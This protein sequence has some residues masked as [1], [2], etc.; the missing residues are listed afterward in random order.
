[1]KTSAI[2][3]E[4]EVYQ[5]FVRAEDGGSNPLHADIPVEVYI[6]SALDRP[7]KFVNRNSVYFLEEG[8]PVG[9]TIAELTALSA[10]DS[11]ITY[12]M[13]ST[14]YQAPDSLFQVDKS[15][16]TYYIKN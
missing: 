10:P 7:P 4:N 16:N 5:F 9:K 13:A 3:L 15:Y 8:T 2:E 11:Q 12:K 1:M 6:M 14:N